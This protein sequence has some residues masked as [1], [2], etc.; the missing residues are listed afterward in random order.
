MFGALGEIAAFL[1]L[2]VG[3]ASYLGAGAGA[4][5]IGLVVGRWFSPLLGAVLG[6]ALVGSMA[7]FYW[8]SDDSDLKAQNAALRAKQAEL[9]ATTAALLKTLQEEREASESNQAVIEQLNKKLDNLPDRPDCNIGKG[10]VDEL[11]KIR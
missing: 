10:V 4:A 7:V 2:L 6:A 11:N 3:L 5:M 8:A 1:K 9:R